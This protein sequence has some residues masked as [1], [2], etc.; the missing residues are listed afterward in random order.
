MK[1]SFDFD[2]TLSRGDVQTYAKEL[3]DSNIEVWIVTARSPRDPDNSVLFSVAE[4]LG[5]SNEHIKFTAGLR[6]AFFFKEYP[7]FVWHLDDDVKEFITM[8]NKEVKPI[9]ISAESPLYKEICNHL[10][11]RL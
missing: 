2:L 11:N 3:L 6:K 5:I 4:R 9:G 8:E 10:L 7:D 1:V